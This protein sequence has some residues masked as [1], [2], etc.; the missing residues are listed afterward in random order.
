MVWPLSQHTH[1]MVALLAEGVDRNRTLAIN[2]G[3]A[4]VALL[5]EGVDRNCMAAS[6]PSKPEVALL[7]EGVDRNVLMALVATGALVALLAEGVDRNISRSANAARFVGSPSSRRAWI[8]MVDSLLSHHDPERR[9][10][11]GGRG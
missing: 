1:T 4:A 6:M 5:A 10:P 7:A 11:R 3:A 8:E 9:P 2:N